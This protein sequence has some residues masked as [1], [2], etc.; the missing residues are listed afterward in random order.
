MDDRV[1]IHQQVEFPIQSRFKR[2]RSILS[3]WQSIALEQKL[4]VPEAFENEDL[5]KIQHL[6]Q[7]YHQ[8]C[9]KIRS[10]QTFLEKWEN[11]TS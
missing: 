7:N 1:S 4:Q 10:I 3:N 5:V 6:M 8:L 11:H 9:K 2:L